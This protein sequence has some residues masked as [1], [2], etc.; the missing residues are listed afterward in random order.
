V[1]KT[2]TNGT[3]KDTLIN[4]QNL[5]GSSFDDTFIT[6]LS[7]SNIIDGG[8]HKTIGDTIDYSTNGATKI[9]LDLDISHITD[10]YGIGVINDG[11]Y[12]SV[13]VE[14][15]ATDKITKIENIKGSVGADTIYGNAENNTIYG[16]AG[17][18]TIY[19]VAGKNY[20]DGGAG[21]DLIYSGIGA[22]RLFGGTGSDTF[23]GTTAGSFAGDVIDGGNELDAS[24]GSDTVDYHAITGIT[25]GVK[26]TLNGSTDSTVTINNANSHT[27]KNIEN[28]IGTTFDDS[29]VGDTGNNTLIGESGA[30]TI[31]GIAGNNIIY[32]DKISDDGTDTLTNVS[33]N[34]DVI[35]AG[36]GQDTIYAGGGDD[37]IFTEVGSDTIYGGSGNDKIYGGLGSKI[38]GGNYIN[39][40]HTDSGIDTVSYEN[41]STSVTVRLDA[42]FAIVAATGNSD[43]IFGIEN[44]IGTAF[45]DSIV[46]DIADNTLIGGAGND[47]LNGL[48]GNNRL[49]GG[50]DNDT[51]ISGAGNNYVDGGTGSDTVDY[52]SLTGTNFGDDDSIAGQVNGIYYS[53]IKVDLT[54]TS[55]QRIHANYGTDTILN[56][57]NVIGST[58]NDYIIGNDEKNIL[59]GK[60]GNDYF[61]LGQGEDTILGDMGTD[62]IA[63][64]NT[65]RT[66][67]VNVDLNKNQTYGST[68]SYR[69]ISDGFGNAK[70]LDSIE[71]VIGTSY[72]D[73]IFGNSDANTLIGG[74]GI[75]TLK[76]G[77][78]ADVLDGG[79]GEDWAYFNDI[80]VSGVNIVLDT[81]GNIANGSSG[82]SNITGYTTTLVGIEHIKATALADTIR[83]DDNANSILAGSG[84]D[85][86]YSSKGSDY[87]DG[88]E[89]IDT[90]DYAIA[91]VTSG[92][93]IDLGATQVIGTDTT[94][95]VQD[96]GY[97]NKELV[98]NIENVVGTKN[99]DFIKGNTQNNT[100]WAGSGDDTLYG[101]SGNNILIGGI[102]SDTF[103]GGIGDNIIYG[104]TYSSSIGSA[105]SET[106]ISSK[107]LIDFTESG[108]S[109]ILNL[110]DSTSIN[111][112][113]LSSLT[114]DARTSIGYGK[115]VIYNVENVLGGSGSDTLIGSNVANVIDGGANNDIIFGF[116]GTGNTL[117]GGAGNDTIMGLLGGDKIYGGT[118]D[119]TTATKSGS[120]W[121]D[122][123]Y[124]T[125]T[126]AINVDLS[127]VSN[128]VSQI[129]TPVN[130]D[131]LTHIENVVGTK[132]NDILKGDDVFTTINSLLG[133]NGDDTFIVSKGSDYID[134][135]L[136]INTMD[137]SSVNFADGGNRVIVDLGLSEAT[138]NGYQ[139]LG[140][141]V[142]DTLLNIQKVIGTSG[143]DTLYGSSYA[144]VF[145]G[146]A[147]N[148][149]VDGREGADT[150]Y[151]TSGNN[152]LFGG[153]DKD[154]IYGGTGNDTLDGG[155]D[156]DI[157][158]G[159]LGGNNTFIGATGND[160]FTGGSGVDTLY[161]LNAESGITVTLKPTG[162]DGTI[163]SLTDGTDSLKT[164]FERIIATNFKDTIDL[165]KAQAANTILANGGN[166]TVTASASYNDTIYGG[167]GDDVFYANGGNNIYYGGNAILDANGDITGSNASG[168]DTI[169]YSLSTGSVNV[170]LTNNTASVNGFGGTDTIY[171]IA[172]VTGSNQNDILKGDVGVN[173]ILAENGDDWIIATAGN[174]EI[175]GGNH[176]QVDNTQGSTTVKDGG[177]DWLSFQE[178]ANG[179]NA[180][181]SNNSI[182]FGGY[183]PNIKEIEN[184]FGSIYNDILRG[185]NT[186][187]TLHGYDGNDVIYGTA[188]NNFLIGGKGDDTLLGGSGIDKYDGGDVS[189]GTFYTSSGVHGNNTISFY[190]TTSA[191][192]NVDLSYDNGDG[193]T[194]RVL[195]DGYG[196]VE[197]YIRNI[198]N[199]IG[200]L[201]YD[202]T[203]K[204]NSENNI[205]N[206][207]GG[208][209]IIYGIAGEN[210]VIAGT[211][212]DTI[213]TAT[214]KTGANRGDI[215]L[216]GQG[217]DTIVSSFNKDLILGGEFVPNGGSTIYEDLVGDWIDYSSL[218][219]AN[220]YGISVNLTATTS[221]TLDSDRSAYDGSYSL[222]YKLDATGV[223]TS[224]FDYIKGIEYIKGSSYIDTIMG[225]SGANSILAGAG[226]DTIFLDA[227]GSDYIDGGTGSN[228]LSLESNYRG[229]IDLRSAYNTAGSTNGNVTVYNI[230][231]IL[232]SQSVARDET[233]WGRSDTSWNET[234]IMFKGND[235]VL[236]GLGNDLYDMGDGNDRAYTNYGSDTLIGGAGIDTIDHWG[237]YGSGQGSVIILNN[238]T[239]ADFNTL[240]T[241][242]SALTL[243][244]KTV[245]A[246]KL[247]ID[248][249]GVGTISD[250]EHWFYV[251]TDGRG[252]TDYMYSTSNPLAAFDAN[253]SSPDFE[254]YRLGGYADIFS[255][256]NL[257]E[258]VEAMSGDDTIW[259]NAGNDIIYGGDGR[260]T[261]FGVSGNNQLFGGNDNDLIF[262]GTGTDA[263]YGEAGDDTIY[264]K[265]GN[266]VID[267]GA[268][269]DIIYA[270]KGADNING[271]TGT[272]TLRFDGGTQRVVVNLGS[273]SLSYDS[274]SV[275]ANSFVNSWLNGASIQTGIVT[276]I[277]NVDGTSFN[278]T[279]RG[280]DSKNIISGADGDDY[281]F[282]SLGVDEIYGGNSVN[283]DLVDFSLLT[284]LIQGSGENFNGI[285]VNL[286]GGDGAV[287]ARFSQIV[288]TL[289][290]KTSQVFSSIENII[291]STEND[292]IV[293]NSSKNTLRGGAGNDKI[294]GIAGANSLYGDSGNDTIF[295]GTGS[296]YIDGGADN[297]TVDY[298][299]AHNSSNVRVNLSGSAQTLNAT[300]TNNMTGAT[301][302]MT[303]TLVDIQNVNTG[304]GNDTIWGSSTKNVID[305]GAGNDTIFVNAG[306][307]T[308]NAGSGADIIYGGTD[309]EVINAQDGNDS[310]VA[311]A[312]ADEI[313]G[314]N[315]IDLVDY[316]SSST[317]ITL[318]LL[319][320]GATVSVSHNI[321]GVSSDSLTNIEGIKGSTNAS[322]NLVGNNQNN[323]LIGGDLTDII[324]GVSGNN[325]LN[326]GA[327][328]DTIY[329]GTGSDTVDGGTGNNDWLY[330]TDLG[331]TNVTVNLRDNSAIYGSSTDSIT[332]IEHLT[333][334]NGT[335]L[336]Q[337]N[338]SANSFVGGSGA[339]TLSYSGATAGIT[340]NVTSNGAGT[341]NGDGADTF[342]NFENYILSDNADTAN[343][344]GVHGSTIDGGALSDTASYS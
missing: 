45:A 222:V 260:D 292:N 183:T 85:T 313:D 5:V 282:A 331:S 20:I 203:L 191:G 102:G 344:S 115:N 92:L 33:T 217:T 168:T 298:T 248:L 78:G 21:N 76:G 129:G 201:N 162:E 112:L 9:I 309:V 259:A 314:G 7:E 176:T 41:I 249:S 214:V 31:K 198:Q 94:W 305:S 195:N 316:S 53:G 224:Q 302:A 317:G 91:D 56:I 170:N 50:D 267:A 135:G 278:D 14:N 165:S 230:Q 52:S 166:D 95:A 257:S 71:N 334:S 247:T 118:F 174:D 105:G 272:D 196:N 29:I 226:D 213:Y 77:L 60:G 98:Y 8:D 209:D 88:E 236:G 279:V 38:Y 178:V 342:L 332:S 250:G 130:A 139:N 99:N 269:D 180:T 296:D 167:D 100:I 188:G 153:K 321:G 66:L 239:A 113:S 150:I 187:N 208:H 44:V 93:I 1:E 262:G 28:I 200:S 261:I 274:T 62:T 140:V 73:T 337:G 287:G 49:E 273:T 80:A 108:V 295:S 210:T 328:D 308:I 175:S 84:T 173:K 256:S 47:T 138:D 110:S 40:A 227:G 223:V 22:D 70:Y 36:T 101:V 202:D 301:S 72:D 23:R 136:G 286:G 67:G 322:N 124:I 207:E 86:I 61:V 90:I 34:N 306:N 229:S 237:N 310:I 156:D 142:K 194:G 2:T 193:T 218:L 189:I 216:G 16:M 340:L 24:R 19:G 254:N 54:N 211:G 215:V 133:Y 246:V 117:I 107:D 329:A 35:Y 220:T 307:D 339:D 221:L 320:D 10:I 293:G 253:T 288:S 323:T 265:V 12:A 57:E 291:G 244:N 13:A 285:S 163:T 11:T 263:I 155:A 185:D 132:N 315:N 326:G 192:V 324:K 225:D 58:K 141:A 172:N 300:T 79:T 39:D 74:A 6:K 152:K 122:Y 3:V 275:A 318:T 123:S 82:T 144:N 154:T 151:G 232:G 252:Y 143:D 160:T 184:L 242:M 243:T 131:T 197:T 212:N 89:G 43:I 182:T 304:A 205:I 270:G 204:G 96:D 55:A 69:V 121:V 59:D 134:G 327:G 4:I 241:G 240:A 25:T 68:D 283:G 15:G 343:L 75:D 83:G 106:D 330:Y 65:S 245:Q 145:V 104:E 149:Y 64:T 251:T 157:L 264:A 103:R 181:M 169:N 268:N 228:W 127:A 128:Q 186:N 312:G 297:N 199:I 97:G 32:G 271:N 109:I 27:I 294:Y 116:G 87:I 325:S 120:D 266:N 179:L 290:T 26:V 280:N 146:G 51:L 171:N 81:D 341:S 114:L 276:N 37:T 335:N 111:Y 137:Y 255:G 238:I 63:F 299:N 177:G 119:G 18:D 231:N 233:V 48:D 333:M 338:Q 147:G 336:V 284:G 158:D 17:N 277:E 235:T 190:D 289:E 30:D 164:H 303:D 46:G 281:V 161:Y 148:D 159:S 125:D 126:R 319:N 311:S 219:S 258:T 42:N 234:F 206:G